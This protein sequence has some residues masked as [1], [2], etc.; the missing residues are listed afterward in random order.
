MSKVDKFIAK[1]S[2]NLWFEARM[3]SDDHK[4]KKVYC[5][6]SPKVMTF[7]KASN[8]QLVLFITTK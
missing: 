4:A 1:R 3:V 8:P 6:I 2:H 7:F 5:Y